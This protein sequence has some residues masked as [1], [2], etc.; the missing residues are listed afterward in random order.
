MCEVFGPRG[1]IDLR[2]LSGR[3]V[4]VG[5]EYGLGLACALRTVTRDVRYVF[6][7]TDPGEL[8]AVLADLGFGETATVV[9]RSPDRSV[10][11]QEAHD[12]AQA[13]T[14]PFDLVVSGDAA[15][16]H[17]VR[18]NARQRPRRPTDTKARAY[19]AK[20]RTGLD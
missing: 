6:E 13:S 16:V 20:G 18:R 7:A 12:A 8:A 1:S 4:F 5:D 19:W 3:V 14:R 10:V 11:T 9:L 2:G 15:T 17:A